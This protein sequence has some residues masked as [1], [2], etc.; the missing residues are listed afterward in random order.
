[1]P[2]YSRYS[3]SR[4]FL[5]LMVYVLLFAFA[6]VVVEGWV[7]VGGRGACIAACHVQNCATGNCVY[8]GPREVCRCSRCANGKPDIW[9]Y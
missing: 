7:C 5:S 6:P 3:F 9:V 4:R 8:S 2:L 1:M